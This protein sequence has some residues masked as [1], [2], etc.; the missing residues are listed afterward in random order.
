MVTSRAE[1]KILQLELWLEPARLGL[2]T[3]MYVYAN[4]YLQICI[5]HTESLMFSSHPRLIGRKGL[6]GRALLLSIGPQK[7]IIFLLI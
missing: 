2:I 5:H 6:D 3:N 1:L 7:A 4:G